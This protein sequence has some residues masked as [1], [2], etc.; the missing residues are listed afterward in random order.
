MGLRHGLEDGRGVSP[1]LEAWG[2][3]GW[4]GLWHGREGWPGLNNGKERHSVRLEKQISRDFLT[5]LRFF[6]KFYQL[7]LFFPL[8]SP[9]HPS[10]PHASSPCLKPSPSSSPCLKPMPSPCLKPM[11]QAH[12]FPLIRPYSNVMIFAFSRFPKNLFRNKRNR[13]SR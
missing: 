7:P 1:G 8:L 4:L 11:P 9:S 2:S 6:F 13:R 3:V 5:F 10:L 12:L